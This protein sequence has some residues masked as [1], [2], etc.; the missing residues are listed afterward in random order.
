MKVVMKFLVLFLTFFIGYAFGVIGLENIIMGLKYELLEL[1]LIS[2]IGFLSSLITMLLFVTYIIGRLLVIKKMEVTMLETL[3]VSYSGELSGFKVVEEITLGEDDTESIYLTSI[4]P[5]R[6]VKVYEYDAE[7]DKPGELVKHCGL[8]RNG[9]ALKINTYLPCGIPRYLLEYQRFDY[10]KG[11][12]ILAENGLSG[13]TL[14]EV[15]KHT[16]KSYLY[17]LVY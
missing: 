14:N 11:T 4:E 1:S 2:T 12:V 9:E 5:L 13:L 10:V 3:G 6:E 17:Y 15:V 8:L 16:L 7:S